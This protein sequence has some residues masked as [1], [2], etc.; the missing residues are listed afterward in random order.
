M[1]TTQVAPTNGATDLKARLKTTWMSGDYD[2]FCRYMQLG[3][4]HFY[5]RL[6]IPMG[7]RLLDVGCGAGQLALIAAR[8]GAHATGCDIA[9]NW[10]ERA[11]KRALAEGLEARF[12]EGDAESLPYGS[13]E[14]D[15]VASLV[16]AMFAPDPDRAAKEML[17]VC[18]SGGSV[19]MANWT[20]GG[21]IGEMFRTI[22][23]HIAPPG[24]PS[25][26]LWGDPEVV[27]ERLGEGLSELRLTCRMYP[28][29]YPF[30]PAGVVEFFR[31]NYG[32][33]TRAFD[34]L[35]PAGQE[36][37]RAEL[38]ELWSDGNLARGGTTFVEAEYLEVVGVRA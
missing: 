37:L 14:F 34:S 27:K 17:R 26:L 16:G 32:P 25:P 31:R 24:M 10:L 30:G 3:A 19:A 23:R 18:R 11:R 2:V 15:V 20:A 36:R 22:A 12:D 9:P 13:G 5:G 1:T 38:L 33:M 7:A 35:S 8:Q 4:E 6:R 28:F 21:F 29:A